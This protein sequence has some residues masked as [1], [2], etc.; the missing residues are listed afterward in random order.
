MVHLWQEVI[1]V[2]LQLL[3]IIKQR[4]VNQKKLVLKIKDWKDVGIRD[5]KKEGREREEGVKEK[6]EKEGVKDKGKEE[7]V[8][9]KGEEGVKERGKEEED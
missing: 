7:G 1:K 4:E 2:L 6:G 8:K 5:W 3:N 9:D